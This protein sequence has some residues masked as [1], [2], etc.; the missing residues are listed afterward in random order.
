M[1]LSGMTQHAIA[2]ELGVS[3]M[4]CSQLI[5]RVRAAWQAEAT[6]T[7]EI[8]AAKE[9]ASIARDEADLR[10][11]AAEVPMDD[12]SLY[13]QHID[14]IHKLREARGKILGTDA[15][16]KVAHAGSI[17]HV[18]EHID[19][20][21][22]LCSDPAAAELSIKL[23]ARLDK[24]MLPQPPPEPRIDFGAIDAEWKAQAAAQDAAEANTAGAE[25]PD[26]DLIVASP[27]I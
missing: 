14:R 24:M 2:L 9:L 4:R 8:A 26:D 20:T 13:L 1:A 6:A 17:E 10:R 3:D 22:L 5:S 11:R 23:V 18:H 19:L 25:D 27:S 15:P 7:Y 21:R 12:K 16:T